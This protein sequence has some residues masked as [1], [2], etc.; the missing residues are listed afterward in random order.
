[1]AA[2]STTVGGYARTQATVA[3]VVNMVLNPAIDWL[4]NRGKPAQ[5]VWGLDGL[6]VNFVITSLILSTLVGAFAAWGVRREA[7]AGRLDLTGAPRPGWLTGLGLGTMAAALTVAVAWLLHS[8]GVTT[9]SLWW[10]LAIK[11]VFAG[12]LGFV[13]ARRVIQAHLP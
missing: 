13:V 9:A 11:A 6:V 7:R 8:V 12:T 10:L 5:P 4:T 3:G 2:P 1:M